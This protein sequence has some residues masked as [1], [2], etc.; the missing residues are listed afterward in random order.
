MCDY[1]HAL[2]CVICAACSKELCR[3]LLVLPV[4]MSVKV[5]VSP[6]SHVTTQKTGLISE[7]IDALASSKLFVTLRMWYCG[8]FYYQRSDE[9]RKNPLEGYNGQN[10]LKDFTVIFS[11]LFQPTHQPE[12]GN[13][14][15]G[16]GYFRVV[17][18][19]CAENMFYVSR[20]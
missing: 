14:G 6:R 11:F 5:V 3:G 19:K 12:E 2:T 17:I 15:Y 16:Y 18:W 9:T 1:V 8:A 10:P 4:A 20:Q 7:K 13:C